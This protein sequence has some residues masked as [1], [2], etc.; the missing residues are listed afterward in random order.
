MPYLPGEGVAAKIARKTAEDITLPAYES[1]P[2]N[3]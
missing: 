3:R 1:A 2:V